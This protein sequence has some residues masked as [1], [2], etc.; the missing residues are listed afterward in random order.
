MKMNL[1]H[2]YIYGFMIGKI[3]DQVDSLP[4]G[5]SFRLSRNLYLCMYSLGSRQLLQYWYVTQLFLPKW[6]LVHC[7][8]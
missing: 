5:V 6:Q 8:D 1:K 4:N 7:Q 3:G 2:Y